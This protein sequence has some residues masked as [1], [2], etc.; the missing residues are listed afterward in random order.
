MPT[1]ASAPKGSDPAECPSSRSGSGSS[2]GAAPAALALGPRERRHV[3]HLAEVRTK[4][5][6]QSRHLCI[7][8]CSRIGAF[9]TSLQRNASGFP[10]SG[11]GLMR[12]AF[13]T[14]KRFGV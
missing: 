1:E 14:P 5:W 8:K 10:V 6:I 11:F 13:V 7:R 3:E 2:E 9:L 4:V 12:R